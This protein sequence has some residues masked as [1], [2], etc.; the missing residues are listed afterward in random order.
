[1]KNKIVL[2]TLIVC[3]LASCKTT[4]TKDSP[5]VEQASPP[6]TLPTSDLN[7]AD[8]NDYHQAKGHM[9]SEAYDQA[10]D[11]LSRLHRMRP[12]HTGIAVNLAICEFQLKQFIESQNILNKI[13]DK[14]A[15]AQ[16]YNLQ[17]LLHVQN[18]A[19]IEALKSY[20]R[21]LKLDNTLFDAHFNIALLYDVYFQNIEAA[22]KH[23]QTYLALTPLEDEDTKNW[24]EQL[25][26]SLGN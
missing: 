18:N 4:P 5:L 7:A 19:H 24:L 3:A 12:S 25:K 20:E 26:Y 2:F 21:A 17:G 1:M 8:L 6:S 23:Y 16:A 15:P 14:D 22:Y 13:L 9:V 11:I 10:K